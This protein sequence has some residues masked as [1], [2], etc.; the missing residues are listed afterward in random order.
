MSHTFEAGR[1]HKFVDEWHKITTDSH[2]LDIVKHCHLDINTDDI[3]PLFS[4]EIEYVFSKEEKLIICQE[5]VKLL[6]LK[7]IKVTHRQ[8]DQILSPIFL[9]KKKD[10]GFRMILNLQKLNE[11]IE[12][13]HFKMENFEQAIRLINKDAF[14]ASVDLRHAYYSVKIAEEQQKFL[15]FKWQ[16]MIYQFTCLPNGVAE[17]P[18]LFT[19]LMKPIFATLREQGHI[20]TSFI[21]DTLISHSSF[22]GCNQSVHATVELLRKMGFSIN[23][24]KSVLTPTKSLEYLGNVINSEQMT[25]T[26]PER[27]RQKIIQCC[28]EL[29]HCDRAHIRDVAKVVG[30]LVAATPAVEMGKLHYRRLET[31]KISALKEVGGNFDKWIAI[32]HDMKIDLLWWLN[33]IAVQSRNIFRESAEIDL[34]TDASNLGWGASLNHQQING[35]WSLSETDLHINEK[36]LKAILFAL[37][38]FASQLRG[39]HIKVFCDNTTAVHYVNEMGGT[40]SVM[41]NAI[42]LKIW[43]LCEKIEVW[44]TCSH[45]P[46]RV[47]LLADAASRK[48][49]DRHEWKLSE[50]IFRELCEVFGVP[51]IDLFASRLNKQVP[52]F[53]SWRPDPEA[54]YFDAF[55]I[56]WSQFE[57]VY[58]FPPFALIARCLQKIRAERAR[59][60]MIVPVWPSQA[61]MGSLLTMLIKEPRLIPRGMNV[62]SQP[63]T[64]EEHPILKQTRLMACLL[65][66]DNCENEEFLRQV[67]TSSWPRGGLPLQSSISR[68]L[69]GGYNFVIQG[70]SVP[71]IPL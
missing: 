4:E 11:H 1:L 20:I 12:Y 27:R 46:G 31:A 43:D 48:F 65:S 25:V 66:G 56:N 54:E 58:I 42:C 10:G 69:T 44:V 22:E 67:R 9:R 70:V 37:H 3:G 45:V 57:L 24:G 15:C 19:K 38:S 14:M 28:K 16:G 62:L 26:L 60:W 52:R 39:K 34:Y 49:N 5:I 71:L 35:R 50:A 17:G 40:K 30:L 6:E 59:G 63:S 29:V 18:R 33:H 61:W 2:I 64:A 32:T 21:D 47:N 23:V 36:E 7:V 55:S 41:C 53:C 68:M 13:K 51:N 8:K